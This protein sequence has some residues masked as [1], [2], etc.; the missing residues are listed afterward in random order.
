VEEKSVID[1]NSGNPTGSL[2]TA[3]DH[4]EPKV[5]LAA[6]YPKEGTLFSDNPWVVLDAPWATDEKKAGARDFLEFLRTDKAQD[7]FTDAGFRTYDGK[8]GK[9]IRDDPNLIEDGVTITLSPPAPPVLAGVRTTWGEVRKRA[10]VLLLLDV[11]GSMS[12][13]VSEAGATR[14]ELAKAGITKA[15]AQFAPTDE[16]G[17]WMFTTGLGS[18]D[19]ITQELVPVEPLA[20]RR[21]EVERAVRSLE[22]LD[23]TP[24]YAS[25]RRAVAQM[26]TDYAE[27]KINAVV[28]LTDGRNEYPGDND[29]DGLVRQLAGYASEDPLR[30]FSIAYS[31][32]A[33]LD[34]LRKISEASQ[35]AAYDATDPESIDKVLTAVISNF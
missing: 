22:P 25:I 30:V 3:G 10:R 7:R 35:A 19:G 33:D 16:V 2:D 8:A 27:D 9:V 29:L 4:A 31:S 20:G 17:V 23:G 24:L 11:S 18:E 6:V 32:G 21:S 1:Y 5:P 26:R 12:E 14:L 13:A 34:V 28:V 15:M